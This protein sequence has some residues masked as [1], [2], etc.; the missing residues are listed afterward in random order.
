MSKDNSACLESVRQHLVITA[1]HVGPLLQN[2]LGVQGSIG[3]RKSSLKIIGSAHP[4]NSI[5]H[6]KLA[7]YWW[8]GLINS[9]GCMHSARI[10][11]RC[12]GSKLN[13]TN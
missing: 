4:V 3:G 6:A 12:Y 1:I 9:K 10:N 2:A 11:S 8:T 5:A 13:E 7:D